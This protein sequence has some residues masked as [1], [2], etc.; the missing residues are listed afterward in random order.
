MQAPNFTPSLNNQDVHTVLEELT[1][2]E[3][4]ILVMVTKDLTNQEIA[5]TLF[6]TEMTVKT[7]RQNITRKADVKGKT[8]IRK[9]I[10]CVREFFKTTTTKILLL[11]YLSSIAAAL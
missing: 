5:E 4:K 8:Q 1:E 9:F 10:R 11:Y 3:M 2:Q 7:H 6:I